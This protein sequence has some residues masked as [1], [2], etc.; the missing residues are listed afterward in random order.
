MV[1]KVCTCISIGKYIVAVLWREGEQLENCQLEKYL[2]TGIYFYSWVEIRRMYVHEKQITQTWVAKWEATDEQEVNSQRRL[3]RKDWSGTVTWT[4][5]LV[6][7]F[8]FLLPFPLF[9]VSSCLGSASLVGWVFSCWV[10]KVLSIALPR[11]AK[12]FS[13]SMQISAE[14]QAFCLTTC[15]FLSFYA[16]S[17]PDS[18][19]LHHIDVCE[20]LC[21]YIL[22]EGRQGAWTRA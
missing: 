8:F 12:T 13:E 18:A 1:S 19:Y 6:K 3:E 17:P 16:A 10:R 7:V 22:L 14:Y 20:V 15:D 21:L 11:G 2:E 9:P 4:Y 5:F